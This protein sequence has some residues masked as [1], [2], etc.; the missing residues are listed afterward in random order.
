MIITMNGRTLTVDVERTKRFYET[1]VTA[2]ETCSCAGCRNF[3]L[4]AEAL[5]P[6]V[7]A[8][9][10]SLGVDA[11]KPAEIYVLHAEAD[12]RALHYGGFYHLCGR[13]ETGSAAEPGFTAVADGFAVA[14]T[15][16]I[17]LPEQTLP[18][19]ALQMEIDFCGVPWKL[20]T[21]NPY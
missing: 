11:R 15:D 14:F 21:P 19:P 2:A 16:R 3:G 18:A 7:G 4:A 13:L 6:A 10:A 8:F 12:G 20:D 5:P 9:F 1:C 17:D